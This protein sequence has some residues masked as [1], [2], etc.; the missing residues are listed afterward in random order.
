M[1]PTEDSYGLA[2]RVEFLSAELERRKPQRVLD[3]GCGTGDNLTTVLA[4]RFPQ[5]QF[6]GVDSDAA[7]IAYAR[8]SCG[9]RNLEFRLYP[10]E[11]AFEEDFDVIVASEVLEH[12]DEPD[13]FLTTLRGSLTPG[14]ALLITVP[15]GYGP[16]ELGSLAA[17]FLQLTG[18]YALLL[19]LK[20]LLSGAPKQ[21]LAQV[22]TLAV[23]PHVNFFSFGE[24]HRLFVS[25]GLEMVSYRS[26]TFLCG[27]GFDQLL[28]GT[29]ALRWN[30]RIADRL[31]P[32]I[33]SDWMFVL[34]PGQ[35]PVE[36]RYRRG[37][38]ARLRRWLNYRRYGLHEQP[39]KP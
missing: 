14:G 37:L 28:R 23:S 27:F 2:K 1:F 12:V 33:V 34:V 7:S 11:F 32:Q 17:T 10:G 6:V 25:R 16:Y 22:D 31:P 38:Y 29:V 30:A 35:T 26:R 4:A 19:K 24:L 20:Q 39:T 36:G 18:L 21:N 9:L 8:R 5:I 15:N 13:K 3:Y